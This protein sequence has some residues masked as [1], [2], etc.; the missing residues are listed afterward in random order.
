VSADQTVD[1]DGREVT[2]TNLDK[3]L[4]PEFALTKAWLVQYYD[5]VAPAILPHLR[6][7]PA[8]LHRFPDGVTGSHW[9]QTRAPAHP[10][11][12]RTMVMRPRRTGKVFD[13]VVIDDRASLVWAANLGTVEFHPYLGCV[14]RIDEPTVVVFDLDPGEG[15]TIATVCAVA[16]R[17]RALL[18]GVGLECFAKTTGGVGLHVYVPL[19]VPH[20]YDTTKAFARA[21]AQLLR[22]DDPGG[23][24]TEMPRH[25]RPGKV[26]VDWSQNDGGKSTVAPYSLR[27]YGVPT[28]ST[29][30]TWE[31]VAHAAEGDV[32]RLRFTPA[33][34]LARLDQ[35]GDQFAAV[36]TLE[37]QLPT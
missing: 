3:V 25:A 11:W 7:K 26:F 17:L 22:D 13:V 6:G 8:T 16:T 23:I 34:A 12:V 32:R 21:V 35:V 31:E 33:E 10:P 15:V 27:G 5:D 9:Y 2:L 14:E 36:L 20:T 29:P 18:R 37:Q 4:W 1:V 24:T 19:N 28:V 30:V